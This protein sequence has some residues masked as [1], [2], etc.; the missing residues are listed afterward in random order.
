MKNKNIFLFVMVVGISAFSVQAA[1]LTLDVDA[2]FDGGWTTTFSTPDNYHAQ[3]FTSTVNYLVVIEAKFE[4]SAVDSNDFIV[5]IWEHNEV[6]GPVGVSPLATATVSGISTD[7]GDNVWIKWIMEPALDISSYADVNEGLAVVFK[8]TSSDAPDISMNI[9]S[10]DT[11][12][13]GYLG[14]AYY[15][16]SSS[17]SVWTRSSNDDLT[18]RIY[19]VDDLQQIKEIDLDQY[20]DMYNANMTTGLVALSD[21]N[22]VGTGWMAQ[23]F[24]PNRPYLYAVEVET[25]SSTG[26]GTDITVELW[27]CDPNAADGEPR[28]GA[29]PIAVAN[30][31]HVGASGFLRWD[32]QPEVD[33]R[34]YYSNALAGRL[35]FLW[36]GNTNSIAIRRPLDPPFLFFHDAYIY[37]IAYRLQDPL[38]SQLW[39]DYWDSDT[40]AHIFDV[41]FLTYGS[42]TPFDHCSHEMGVILD[43]DISGPEGVPDCTVDFYDFGA[44]AETWGMQGY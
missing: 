33:L 15:S 23:S 18:L 30:S 16:V 2:S 10:G 13:L 37:G 7:V 38:G 19:G 24:K 4:E 17:G 43:G 6:S 32:F 44:L 27:D 39:I 25:G 42:Y 34:S 28:V 35:M 14:G 31:Y 26:T 12:G 40:A 5:E 22:D 36:K 9:G 11:V 3:S 41:H 20:T 21:G 29:S 8:T 1:D